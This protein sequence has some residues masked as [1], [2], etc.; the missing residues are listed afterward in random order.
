MKLYLLLVGPLPGLYI[1]AKTG[2]NSMAQY[3]T[4][5]TTGTVY[6]VLPGVPLQ[7]R[8]NSPEI[9]VVKLREF[10]GMEGV[11]FPFFFRGP[12]H[13]FTAAGERLEPGDHLPGLSV[14]EAAITVAQHGHVVNGVATTH[15][16][17]P[18]PSRPCSTR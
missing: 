10:N 12:Y 5:P 3:L 15:K 1:A 13:T 18:A 16:S 8:V 6:G 2:P 7:M 14:E 11:L 17:T 9:A 4:D